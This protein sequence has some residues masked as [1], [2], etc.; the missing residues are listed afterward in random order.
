MD[1]KVTTYSAVQLWGFVDAGSLSGCCSVCLYVCVSL[2]EKKCRNAAPTGLSG[3]LTQH[4]RLLSLS[5]SQRLFVTDRNLTSKC[6][7]C[8]CRAR[9]AGDWQGLTA[10]IGIAGNLYFLSDSLSWQEASAGENLYKR[11]GLKVCVCVLSGQSKCQE[12]MLA[13]YFSAKMCH[14]PF[15]LHVYYLTVLVTFEKAA[16]LVSRFQHCVKSLDISRGPQD[17]F[18]TFLWQQQNYIFDKKSGRLRNVCGNKTGC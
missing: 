16:K 1:V 17:D 11:W 3:P 6:Q 2:K 12:K 9:T 15:T 13:G 8:S 5:A 7:N 4:R 10:M 14:I 18:Q